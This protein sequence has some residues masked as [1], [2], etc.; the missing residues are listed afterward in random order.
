MEGGQCGEYRSWY[1]HFG[2]GMMRILIV[3]TGSI[4]RRHI[5]NLQKLVDQPEFIFLRNDAREDELSRELGAT[6]V[7]SFKD[8][9]ALSPVFAVIATPSVLHLEALQAL[10]SAQVPCYVEKPVVTTEAQVQQ[11]ELL[12]AG[13]TAVPTTMVGCNLRFLPSL[14]KARQLIRGGVLGRPVRASLQVGQWL[15]DWR[16]TQ[17]YRQSYSASCELGGGVVLDL[18]HELDAARWL[19]GEFDQIFALG[20]RY[21]RLEIE[22]ED[23]A[24]I[25]LGR[26]HG[27]VVSIGLDYVSHNPVRRYEIIGDE[28]SLIWDLPAKT[29]MLLRQGRQ[30]TVTVDPADF[31]VS[32][33]YINA[34]QEFLNAIEGSRSTSQDLV[35][36]LR[37]A[38]LAVLI[39]RQLR[40]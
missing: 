9:I 26:S 21:S 10:L 29:A 27:P 7:E 6:V 1:Y 16:P 28:G 2:S 38:H 4:G 20:G 17:D 12:L 33:T 36:G 5:R 3:G 18:I 8:G 19:F 34:I 13:A 35:D 39:N 32:A 24:A 37:S 40:S 15:P 30:E 25:I 11:L 31:D 23:S 14:K 22:S